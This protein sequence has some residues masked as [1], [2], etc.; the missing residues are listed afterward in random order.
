M[1]H[2]IC[3]TADWPISAKFQTIV[4]SEHVQ[5]RLVARVPHRWQELG[6]WVECLS[7]RSTSLSSTISSIHPMGYETNHRLQIWTFMP[8]SVHSIIASRQ[9]STPCSTQIS[10]HNR[11]T[12]WPTCSAAKSMPHAR[13]FLSFPIIAAESGLVWRL[14]KAG[15]CCVLHLA[16]RRSTSYVKMQLRSP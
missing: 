8:V 3:P 16:F 5:L 10:L 2:G 14:G 13:P 12:R 6:T 11:A 4:Q 9:W 1:C 15:E 7:N